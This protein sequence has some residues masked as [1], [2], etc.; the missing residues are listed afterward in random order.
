MDN[1]VPQNQPQ[2]IVQPN[3]PQGNAGQ[4]APSKKSLPK[5]LI[6][7]VLLVIVATGGFLGYSLLSEGDRDISLPTSRPF[8][9]RLVISDSFDSFTLDTEK[10]LDWTSDDGARVVQQ[11]S[12]VELS[13]LPGRTTYTDAGLNSTASITGDFEVSVDIVLIEGGELFGSESALVFHDDSWENQI[14]FYV[15]KELDNQVVVHAVTFTDGSELEVGEKGYDYTGPFKVRIARKG[16][17]TTFSVREND[18]FV[19]IGQINDFYSGDG[20]ITLHVNSKDPDF[21]TVLSGFDNFV[22]QLL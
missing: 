17:T 5:I 14:S 12:R 1:P 2:G 21:P 4:P 11:D 10:W 19:P 22:L 20:G 8:G 3:Q 7:I 6:V 16:K 13:I 18:S 9:P 15:R